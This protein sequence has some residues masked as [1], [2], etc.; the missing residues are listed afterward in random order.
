ML[1]AGCTYQECAD[2]FG[3]SKGRIG[4]IASDSNLKVK[5][6]VIKSEKLTKELVKSD[7]QAINIV[8]GALVDARDIQALVKKAVEGDKEAFNH[9]KDLGVGDKLDAFRKANNDLVSNFE[10]YIKME[11]TIFDVRQA[12][13]FQ[14]VVLQAI[15]QC[16]TR[17]TARKIIN[18][19]KEHKAEK[20]AL[21]G[22]A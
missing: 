2:Y 19:I 6:A 10:K 20:S 1:R 12:L 14:E 4:Q 16:A 3:V 18:F 13:E 8:K 9:L 5:T 17:E 15:K 21:A 11:K 7:F 22:G